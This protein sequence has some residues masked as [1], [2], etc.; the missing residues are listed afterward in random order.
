MTLTSHNGE[1]ETRGR[2]ATEEYSQRQSR[3]KEGEVYVVADFTSSHPNKIR[4]TIRRLTGEP[5]AVKENTRH[6]LDMFYRCQSMW[7]MILRM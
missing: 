1:N 5:K 3:C 4:D 7:N 2:I 6:V